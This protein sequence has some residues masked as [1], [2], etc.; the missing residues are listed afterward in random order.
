MTRKLLPL[1]TAVVLAG[2]LAACSSGG[3]GGGDA[4][5]DGTT[6]LK[7]AALEGGYGTQMYEDVVAAYAKVNPDVTIELQT[8]KSIE[9]EI[10]PGM[11]AGQYPDL[12][13]LGQGRQAALT[14]TLIKDQALTDL[15]DVLD[16]TVPGEDVTVGEK[17]T[18]GIVGNLNTNPYGD[19][20]T[21][22]M[23]MYYAPTG[24]VY[25]QGLFEEKGW[26]VPQTWDELF[27]LGDAAKAEGISL[28]TYPTAG[29]LDSYFFSLLATVGGED[30][31]E[32]VMTYAEGVWTTDEATEAIDLT[33]RL[34]S[35]AAPTTVGYANEQDFTKNQQQILDRESV[36]MPNG[37]WIAGEMADAP[38]ADGFTWGLT[39][40]P[41]LE[42]GG[43]RYLTTSVESAWI[44]A[45]AKNAD[46]AKEFLAY[47]YSDEAAA[48]FADSNAVQPIDG[49]TA[50]LDPELAAFY[51]EYEEPGVT[52]LVGGFASTAPV[53]GVNIKATLFDTANS[54]ISGDKTP[55]QWL[56]DLDTASEKLRAAGE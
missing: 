31:Y 39:P 40:L 41:A 29:Y 32:D 35:Y 17:L 46:A 49:I 15:T 24:L 22:L 33:A 18:D 25:D 1:A 55:E 51:A 7:V 21:Y 14:E 53:E 56:A 12:V 38:R 8:S 16:A 28:F 23:P 47:L 45:Q 36:F 54:I 3:S 30:F 50:D 48:I 37:T 20:A 26:T 13:V 4:D 43:D 27:A 44:P 11:K 19:D 6:T 52:A 2:S 42:E 10:T 34:L 9:D 5:A